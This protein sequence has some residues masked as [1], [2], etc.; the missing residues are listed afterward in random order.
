MPSM[1]VESTRGLAMEAIFTIIGI[2]VVIVVARL[3]VPRGPTYATYSC[4]KCPQVQL[5]VGEY[6]EGRICPDCGNPLD[7][8]KKVRGWVLNQ[9]RRTAREI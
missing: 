3:L 4:M 7:F 8:H 6:Q 9:A 1:R 2:I 5:F